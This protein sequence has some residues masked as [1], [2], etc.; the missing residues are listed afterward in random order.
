VEQK[1]NGKV[2]NGMSLY[3]LRR[4]KNFVLAHPLFVPNFTGQLEA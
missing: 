4:E 1:T 3:V 2:A